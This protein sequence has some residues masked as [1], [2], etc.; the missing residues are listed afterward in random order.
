MSVDIVPI[1]GQHSTPD[2]NHVLAQLVSSASSS[3][4]QQYLT[5]LVTRCD[6]L[7]SLEQILTLLQT[8]TH[9]CQE[10]G[11]KLMPILI[12]VHYDL[13]NF[14][15]LNILSLRHHRDLVWQLLISVSCINA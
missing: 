15:M 13:D 5:S 6:Q 3:S 10:N 8:S 1:L 11:T 4:T 7:Q 14:E 2:Q 12:K 9:M